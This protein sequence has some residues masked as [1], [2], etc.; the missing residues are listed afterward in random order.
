MQCEKRAF[1][2]PYW[3]FCAHAVLGFFNE[4]DSVKLLL[5][6][7]GCISDEQLEENGAL[8]D[9]SVEL[10]GAATDHLLILQHQKNLTLSVF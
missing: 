1:S 8:V 3:W 9:N 7:V 2:A 6:K 10:G 5:Y 4:R